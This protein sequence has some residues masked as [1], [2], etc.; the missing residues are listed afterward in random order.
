MKATSKNPEIEGMLTALT[1]KNRVEVIKELK[2]MTCS[3]TIKS[4]RDE[5][6]LREYKISGMC[7]ECQDKVFG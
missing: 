5:L 4:F 6:S 7:Q 2:C 1:G 3:D